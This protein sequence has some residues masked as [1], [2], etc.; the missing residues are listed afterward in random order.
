VV[1]QA[2]KSID[3]KVVQLHLQH[4]VVQR[5]LSRFVAQGFVHHD[6]SRACLAQSE[7]NVQRVV[8]LGRLS[9]YG[10]GAIRLHE[11]MLTVTARWV[12]PE[13]RGEGLKPYAREAEART[14]EML[15]QSLRPG[16]AETPPESIVNRLR[17]SIGTDVEQL[18]PH[19]QERGDAARGTAEAALTQ[20]GQAEAAEMR[21]ILEDQR[22]RILTELGRSVEHQLSLLDTDDERRQYE[23][24]RRY[25]QRWVENV[26]GDL[27]R[28][29]E[30]ILAFY[31]TSSYRIEPVGIAYLYPVRS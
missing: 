21:R 11:E 6:L 12:E 24:N 3:D 25:W 26:E 14:L 16:M 1:F 27:L 28:E 15:E 10:A 30:R 7:D 17:E 8:L 5:L 19:L 4:R 18:L 2:P 22:K 13:R 20:R 23:Y 9:M 31:R 29:P